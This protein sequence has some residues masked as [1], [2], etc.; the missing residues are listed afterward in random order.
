MRISLTAGQAVTIFGWMRPKLFL[1]W[2]EVLSNDTLTFKFLMHWANLPAS[3]L[4]HLQPDGRI[5]LQSKRA[6]LADCPDMQECWKVHPIH[7]AGADLGDIIAS[8]WT[9]DTM[10]KIGVTYDDLV[11]TGLTPGN[12]KLFTQLTLAGWA[13]MG[14]GKKHAMTIPERSLESLFNL[15]K[16]DVLRA[17][18]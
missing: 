1:T 7:D 13:K 12:M 11:E 2:E 9:A 3:R 14:F 16:L 4:H 18:K 17:L 8:Q 5:W 6:T 10:L 15:S